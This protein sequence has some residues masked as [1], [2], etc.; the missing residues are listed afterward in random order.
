MEL[1][2]IKLIECP[3]DAMQGIRQFIPTEKK[4]AYINKL[5]KVGFY[6]IDFGSF[7]SPEVIPQMADTAKVLQGLDWQPGDS[8]LIAIIAN[9]RGAA[10]ACAFSQISFLG[11]PFSVSE[12]FQKR[13]TN[14]GMDVAVKRVEAIKTMADKHGK[15]LIIYLSM[16]FGNP[17]GDPYSPEIVIEWVE[18]LS[19]YGIK[20]FMLSDTIGVANPENIAYLFSKL[21]ASHPLLEFGA[22]LHTAPHNWRVKIDAAYF[23]GCRRFDAAIRGYGGCPMAKDE[24]I[25]NMPTENLVNYFNPED[26]GRQFSLSAFEEALRAAGQVFD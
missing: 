19:V 12:T 4:I 16:G 1:P 5:L 3:R 14:A 8:S 7:V 2:K 11:F 18:K 10:D 21:Y 17:Y 26:F 25:G 15:D 6:S 22:H 13:N 20:I 23:N 9:E 24:L